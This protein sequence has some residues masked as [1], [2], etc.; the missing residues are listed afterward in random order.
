MDGCLLTA[1]LQMWFVLFFPHSSEHTSPRAVWNVQQLSS[2]EGSPGAA[3][4]GGTSV[5]VPR[6][7]CFWAARQRN[8]PVRREL[9]FL[10]KSLWISQILVQFFEK[11]RHLYYFVTARCVR[12][13]LA[14][15]WSETPVNVTTWHCEVLWSETQ[16]LDVAG[17]IWRKVFQLRA[18]V[19]FKV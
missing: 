6:Q 5:K 4:E 13:K 19:W 14:I 11:D 17:K 18:V 9:G 10:V 3:L 2:K 15:H 8:C 12:W 1:I 16:D 7:S